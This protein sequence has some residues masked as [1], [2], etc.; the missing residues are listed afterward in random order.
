MEVYSGQPLIS[1]SI[2]N[3]SNLLCFSRRNREAAP[4][5]R[6]SR[7]KRRSNQRGNRVLM[8]GLVRE[9]ALYRAEVLR[10]SG[11]EVAT[12]ATV[13]DAFRAIDGSDFDAVILSYTLP[14]D[15]VQELAERAREH[16]PDCPIV[17]ITDNTRPDRRIA[18][19]AVAIAE[20]GP[21]GLVAALRRV[22]RP[23]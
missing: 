21:P 3:P 13:E 11:Y 22:L 9:L 4:N 2:F 12:P 10:H 5:E 6:D 15:T 1:D 23:T 8:V 17:A 16:C 7:S 20:Q 19:D 18:P 14:N